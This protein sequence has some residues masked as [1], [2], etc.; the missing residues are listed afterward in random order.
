[1]DFM[2]W[3]GMVYTSES[4]SKCAEAITLCWAIWRARNDLVWNQKYTM[5]KRVVAAAKQYFT[6]WKIAQCRSTTALLQPQIEGDGV[7]VWVKPLPN[8]VKFSVDAAVFEDRGG[9]GF[10]MI[11]RDSD[12]LLVEAKA[13]LYPHLVIPFLA[14]AMAIKEAL[15]WIDRTQWPQVISES[16]YLVVVQAIRSKTPMIS[17]FGLIIEDCRSL[18]QRLHKVSLYFDKRSAN[19]VAHQLARESYDYSGRTFDRSY[20]PVN[21]Q[22]CIEMDLST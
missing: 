12:G 13:L 15:S 3:M 4:P 18:M 22:N 14:E 5:V 20:V 17:H 9:V 8:I 10:R 7:S 16:D 2:I 6:Q 19:M 1:M 21:I 11:A